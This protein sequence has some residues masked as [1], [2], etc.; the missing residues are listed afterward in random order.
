MNHFQPQPFHPPGFNQTHPNPPPHIQN[1]PDK[2]VN[3]LEKQMEN[4]MKMFQQETTSLRQMVGQL[5]TQLSEREKGKFP[6]QPE[7]NPRVNRVNMAQDDH[8]SQANAVITLRSGNK[9][10][11][12]VDRP[13]DDGAGP[14]ETREEPTRR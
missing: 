2:R 11:N 10:N 3:T 4:M 14:S 7:P 1:E 6:S 5:A 9:V 8:V 12:N 13:K